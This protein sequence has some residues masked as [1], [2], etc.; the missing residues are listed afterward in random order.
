MPDRACPG[1]DPEAGMTTMCDLIS[2]IINAWESMPKLLSSVN[3]AGTALGQRGTIKE[4]E[5]FATT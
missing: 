4:L 3:K 1:R 5:K 2:S